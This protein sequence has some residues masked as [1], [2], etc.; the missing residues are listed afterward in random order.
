MG[1]V[2]LIQIAW[3]WSFQ[4]RP[5][6]VWADGQDNRLR[7]SKLLHRCATKDGIECAIQVAFELLNVISVV[8]GILEDHIGCLDELFYYQRSGRLCEDLY[9]SEMIV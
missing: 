1:L 6:D 3:D 7:H 9:G 4:V 8:G 5:T 2:E